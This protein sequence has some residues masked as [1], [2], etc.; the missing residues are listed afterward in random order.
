MPIIEIVSLI[1]NRTKCVMFHNVMFSWLVNSEVR[2]VAVLGG[3]K[4]F[5]LC[6]TTQE[7]MVLGV[8]TPTFFK[9]DKKELQ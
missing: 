2:V 9:W 4:A 7:Q 8:Q 1:Y 3:T 5:L 6:L